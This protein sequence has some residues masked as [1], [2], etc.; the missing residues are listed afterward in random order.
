MGKGLLGPNGGSGGTIEGKFGDHWGGNDGTG[1][2]K[3]RVGKGKVVSMGGIG[4]G[5]FAIRSIMSKDGQGSGGL[6]VDSGRSSR[7]SRKSW[8]KRACFIHKACWHAF[9][10]ETYSAL[11]VE[12]AKAV[13]FFENHDVRQQPTKTMDLKFMENVWWVFAE[14]YK[15]GLVYKGFKDYVPTVFDN[16]S[17]NVVVEGITVNLGPWNIAGQEDYNM[18][19]PLSYRG[20]DVFVLAFSLWIPEL[21][22]FAPGVPVVLAGTKLD[23]REDKRYLADHPRLVLVT[24]AQILVDNDPKNKGWSVARHIKLKDVFD[25][26]SATA[27]GVDQDQSDGTFNVSHLDRIGDDGDDRKDVTSNLKHDGT[28]DEEDEVE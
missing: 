10:A 19:R 26:G 25:M 12:I 5:A 3:F 18:L 16:F 27:Q 20:A 11:V 28:D 6:V 4:G 2:S 7:V 21:Q 14:L 23:L 22:H 1:G 9:L 24:T 15:K 17:E 8:G 13:C